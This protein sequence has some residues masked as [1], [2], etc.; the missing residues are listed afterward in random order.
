M[1]FKQK[2]L[3]PESFH[4]KDN[5][6][7]VFYNLIASETTANVNFDP[8]TGILIAS[9]EDDGNGVVKIEAVSKDNENLRDTITITIS[10]QVSDQNPPASV[11]DNQ[12]M[13][14]IYPNPSSGILNIELDKAY[15]KSEIKIFHVSGQLVD[16]KAFNSKK[17]IRFE[18]NAPAGLYF[19]RIKFNNKETSVLKL[20]LY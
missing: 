5:A 20:S 9:G 11:E 1:E 7:L 2:K 18:L 3:I 15:N 6:L 12:N 4:E 16:S 8:S 14:R 10:G 19:I 17:T 13:A